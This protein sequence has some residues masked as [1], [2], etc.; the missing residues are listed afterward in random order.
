MQGGDL[1][2]KQELIEKI[3]YCKDLILVLVAVVFIFLTCLLIRLWNQQQYKEEIESIYVEPPWIKRNE[4]TIQHENEKVKKLR[5][6][7]NVD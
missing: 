5:D 7:Y 6:T 4:E 3:K 2:L 1:L